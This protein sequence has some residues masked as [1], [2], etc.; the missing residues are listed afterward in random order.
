MEF[1]TLRF[2]RDANKS[3][4]GDLLDFATRSAQT[5]REDH[6]AERRG[7]APGR[8][9]LPAADAAQFCHRCR[10]IPRAMII[11]RLSIAPGVPGGIARHLV[12]MSK[13]SAVGRRLT[14]DPNTP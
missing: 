1:R 3:A 14:P 10:M 2:A 9:D 5:L 4:S 11:S 7:Q 12:V 8:G 6:G 13:V